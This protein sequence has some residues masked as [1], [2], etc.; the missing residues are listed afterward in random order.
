MCDVHFCSV[1]GTFVQIK[2][3]SGLFDARIKRSR[4]YIIVIF[5]MQIHNINSFQDK[6]SFFAAIMPRG[7]NIPAVRDFY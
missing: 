4:L 3:L 1:L 7:S 2:R 6:F 5:S